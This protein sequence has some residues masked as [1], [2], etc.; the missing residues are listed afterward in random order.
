[1]TTFATTPTISAAAT[2]SP[3]STSITS[4]LPPHASP[5]TYPQHPSQPPPRT[6]NFPLDTEINRI[7]EEAIRLSAENARLCAENSRLLEENRSLRAN[8]YCSPSL[9]EALRDAL[10]TTLGARV[11]ECSCNVPRSLSPKLT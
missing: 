7:R 3:S 11:N 10:G 5:A 8:A 2:L 4:T 1:M 9:A 6:L